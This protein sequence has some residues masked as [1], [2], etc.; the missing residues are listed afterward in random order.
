MSVFEAIERL[1]INIMIDNSLRHIYKRLIIYIYTH[2][3]FIKKNN[4]IE[5]EFEK[6]IFKVHLQ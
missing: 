4:C 1:I 3:I 2:T 6:T 5:M